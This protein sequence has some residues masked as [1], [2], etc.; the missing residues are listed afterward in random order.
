MAARRSLDLAVRALFACPGLT[1]S[2]RRSQPGT[3]YE[4]TSLS[5]TSVD[6]TR[7]SLTMVSCSFGVVSDLA[8]PAVFREK[9]LKTF[10]EV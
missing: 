8:P 1:S 5:P 6:D 9:V 7:S 4:V 3:T 10:A 2:P